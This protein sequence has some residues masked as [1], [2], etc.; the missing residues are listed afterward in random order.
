MVD[1]QVT[2]HVAEILAEL[3]EAHA[4]SATQQSPAEH[5]REL[6][7]QFR[8]I[9]SRCEDQY[10]TFQALLNSTQ[11]L[12]IIKNRNS[13][14]VYC[15][16][17]YTQ[18][19]GMDLEDIIG[20]TDKDFYAPEQAELYRKEELRV[21]EHGERVVAEH[22]LDIRGTERWYEAVK[23]PLFDAKGRVIGIICLERDI[24]ARKHAEERLNAQ[25]HS[26]DSLYRILL[27][28]SA[29]R[30][31]EAL[32]RDI[33]QRAAE[34]VG[35]EQGSLHL[36]RGD[37]KTQ[38]I[39]AQYNQRD[40]LVGT[41]IPSDAGLSKIVLETGLPQTAEDYN[42]GGN[43]QHPSSQ[44]T[45]GRVLCV[46]LKAGQTII[47]LLFVGNDGKPGT[48]SE[49]DIRLVTLFAEQ[50]AIA[51]VNTRHYE[52]AQREIAQH[53]KQL[54]VTNL[55]LHEDMM[56]REQA[57]ALLHIQ[58]DLGV[59]LSS[60]NDM[61]DALQLCVTSITQIRG[62]DAAGIGVVD[63]TTGALDLAAHI[64]LPEWFVKQVR[65]YAGNTIEAELVR[66]GDPQY[67]DYTT[68]DPPAHATRRDIGIRALAVIP[69][70]HD[71]Q[72]VASIQAGSRVFSQIPPHTR[73]ALESIATQIGGAFSRLRAAESLRQNEKL[74]RIQR[75]LVV[76]LSS[77]SD[78]NEALRHC[79][80]VIV[81]VDGIDA[82]GIYLM[83]PDSCALDLRAYEGLPEWFA[84]KAE[85][86]ERDDSIVQM[87]LAGT[88]V[89]IA[90]APDSPDLDE[91]YREVRFRAL[92]M[93]PIVHDGQTVGSISA[94]SWSCDEFRH[95]VQQTLESIAG[96]ISGTIIRL[97][98]VGSLR[99][100]QANLQNLFDTLID[101]LVVID[102]SSRIVATNPT[103]CRRFGYTAEELTGQPFTVLH[104]PECQQ[105]AEEII[106]DMFEG[107]TNTCSLPFISKDGDIIPV[108]TKITRGYWN[109]QPV[110]FGIARDMSER[111]RF[112]N[113]LSIQRDL[114]VSISSSDDLA[115]AFQFCME[116]VLR[117]DGIDGGGIY[118]VDP[119]DGALDLLASAGLPLGFV[120]QVRHFGKDDIRSQLV[121]AGKAVY[122][123]HACRD[124]LFAESC[125]HAKLTAL[126]IV[127]V[128]HEGRTVAAIDVGSRRYSALPSHTRR[129]LEGIAAQMGGA[130]ARLRT[131][132][133]LRQSK[134]DLEASEARYR[135]IVEDQTEL[136]CRF[137]LD[138]TLSFVN[139]SYCRYFGRT[140]QQLE[141]TS[142]WPFIALGD[143]GPVGVC[144]SSLNAENTVATV[145]CRIRK[146]DSLKWH[147]QQWTCRAIFDAT[148]KL[149][150]I[151]A[152]SRD[153]TNQREAEEERD[154]KHRMLRTLLDT[155]PDVIIVKDRELRY[156]T[157]NR[158]FCR[159][160]GISEDEL[161][162]KT[163]FDLLP[164]MQDA[165]RFEEEDRLVLAN[166]E[167][168]IDRHLT[169]TPIGLRWDESV[170][171]PL[172]GPEEEIIGVLIAARDITDRMEME[173]ERDEQRRRLEALLATTPD[174]IVFKNRDSVYQACSERYRQ[175][176]APDIPMAQ[177]VGK[178]DSDLYTEEDT[179]CY[180]REELQ[181]METGEPLLAEHKLET[182][183]GTRWF[184][185]VKMPLR[186]E[187]GTIIGVFTCER[188][189]T[190]RLRTEAQ[191]D[192]KHRMLRALLDNL[193][194]QILFK[195]R[196]LKYRVI[197]QVYC[198]FLGYK[199][200]ELIG[201]D[202]SYIWPAEDAQRYMEAERR[203]LETGEPIHMEKYL[204]TA[205]GPNYREIV[206]TPLRDDS[207]DIIGVLVAAHDI[208]AIKLADLRIRRR[209]KELAA[210]NTIAS[211]VSQ[212]LDAE[213]ILEISLEE[214]LWLNLVGQQQRG[215]AFMTDGNEKKPYLV[216]DRHIPPVYREDAERRGKYLFTLAAQ[217]GQVVISDDEASEGDSPYGPDAVPHRNL[218]LPIKARTKVIGCINLWLP[219]GQT[220]TQE[221]FFFLKSITDQIGL[222]VENAQ[223]YDNLK[224]E[225]QRVRALSRQLTESAEIERKRLAQDL[226]DMVGQYLT[227]LGINLNIIQNSLPANAT[228]RLAG[229]LHE[230]LSLVERT[231]ECIR[232]VMADL[233]PPVLDDYGLYSALQWYAERFSMLTGIEVRLVGEAL[234]PRLTPQ[235]EATLFRIAQ[236]T[237]VNTAKH[238]Q[239]TRAEVV[240]EEIDEVIRLQISDNG[241]GFAISTL[242]GPSDDKGWG[243][244][245]IRE[246]VEALDGAF[247]IESA[248]EHGTCVTIDLPRAQDRD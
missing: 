125:R 183:E 82:T 28:I 95:S 47:G 37:G 225:H 139:E 222:A 36:L 228:E 195:D 160:Y 200:E 176:I 5:E 224:K 25:A 237:L 212:S 194:H 137:Q 29:Q 115:K 151:Q 86:L 163:D 244:L 218:C 190:E 76:S 58:R 70:R 23:E 4:Q 110:I 231:T 117:I 118:L 2:P 217:Q 49:G 13:E 152:V 155:L 97:Q 182:S 177:L 188:D 157:A 241:T 92:A 128:T 153:I 98:A 248:P 204:E 71:N 22:L 229:R 193:P 45:G 154:S 55:A 30:D 62:I 239:A 178:D 44:L 105:K 141:G 221:D 197:N 147:W 234:N 52:A 113:L 8:D 161:I 19:R 1:S 96:A 236:E 247:D 168:L 119:E 91:Q 230:A 99:K 12:V 32:F 53:S 192:E 191:R 166:G 215:E 60:T 107:E 59:N 213:R 242:T 16:K 203:L 170:R 90:N 17:I 199:M 187:C 100:S 46:P 83:D 201:K 175:L 61:Q 143:R 184:E 51:L 27:G 89:Y 69:I 103:L 67:Y 114:A 210:L 74:L 189:I 34:L 173:A 124:P 142:I 121:A 140:R 48:F 208:T 15:S 148:G 159:I 7:Q 41:T 42:E 146:P 10:Y 180:R 133:L 6:E 185:A 223:L 20:K 126:A 39:V 172:R 226:H 75:D 235:T 33:V 64:G 238:A 232:G 136:I 130:I 138:G 66:R 9:L 85:H 38:E 181:V 240:L 43:G 123:N 171:V 35:A 93:I 245:A 243:L 186:D 220:L 206:K 135:A 198:D 11:D 101:F 149:G 196:D 88:P 26:M 14:F 79:A 219:T 145:T 57:E 68:A 21:I 120:N 209:N 63:P 78:L 94:G 169:E 164:R 65:H 50:A 109:S 202:D 174:V 150:E 104:P 31:L 179:Q 214:M 73:Q 81:Q 77:A 216:A 3:L 106:A 134:A 246:W 87:A 207:G 72:V 205:K 144:L 132:A 112:E 129:A 156:V 84:L 80:E 56:A 162:G 165:I 116:A 24:T 108:E 122:T 40:N 227:A 158:Q 18:I 131:E 211:A 233:R 54:E 127:P 167:T 111:Q 102:A